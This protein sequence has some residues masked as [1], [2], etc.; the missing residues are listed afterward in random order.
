MEYQAFNENAE[1]AVLG[2]MLENDSCRAEALSQ[3]DSED[4]YVRKNRQIFEA[5]R[6]ITDKGITLD[7]ASLTEELLTNMKVFSEIGGLEYI[8]ELRENYIGEK[9]ALNHLHII[10]DLALVRR[11]L[12]E[13][14]LIEKDFKENKITDVPTFVAESE[15]KILDITKTRRVGTFKSSKEIVDK[16]TESLKIQKGKKDL[17]LSGLDTG[18][19]QLNRLMQGLQKGNLIILAARP[20]VGKTALAINLAYNAATS[21]NAR[22]AFF[23]LEMSAES[24]MMRLLANRSYITSTKL[25]TNNLNSDDWLAIN[26]ATELLKRTKLMIDDTSAAKITDIRTKAQKLKAQYPDLG[27]IVIDY[28]G[29]IRTNNTNLDNHQVEVGEISRQLKALAR[30]LNLPI[31]CLCQLSRASERRPNKTPILSDLRDSGSIEQDADQVLFIYRKNYQM[32]NAEKE[33]TV[34]KDEKED[35]NPMGNAEETQIIVAKNRNGQTGIANMVFLM[36][37]GRFIEQET[38]EV[39]Q[40]G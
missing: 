29:L 25:S 21:N 27:L 13:M 3:L 36:N 7:N 12:N 24:I 16:I 30:E 32:Q 11:L 39:Q 37:I 31:I 40:E 35:E 18:Y 9:N 19:R 26:E 17:T 34:V 38:S 14:N 22:V 33:E 23:S 2:S 28:L 4:F 1:K 20:S 15:Q 6:T 10:K 5:I 8:V